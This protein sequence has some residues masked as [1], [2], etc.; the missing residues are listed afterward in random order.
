MPVHREEAEEQSDRDSKPSKKRCRSSGAKKAKGQVSETKSRDV[1]SSE[2]RRLWS[3]EG[4]HRMP[5]MYMVALLSDD[6]DMSM[7]VMPF[8]LWCPAS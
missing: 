1:V 4:I 6:G 8:L 7:C 5:T 3:G 2:W